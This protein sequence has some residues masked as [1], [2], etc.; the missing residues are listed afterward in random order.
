LQQHSTTYILLFAAAV[1][2]VC[3]V[4]VSGAAVMLGERQ[5]ANVELD[6]Q[7]KVLLVAGLMKEGESLSRSE[8]AKLFQDNIEAELVDLQTGQVVDG[9]DASAFNQR[10]AT[11]DPDTSRE[12]PPNPA[13]VRRLPL[14]GQIFRY[15]QDGRLQAVILPITG[16][17]LWSTLYGYLALGPDLD[18][19]VGITFYEHGETPGLGGE[20]DNPR[21]KALWHGRKAF[22]AKGD[23]AIRVIKGAAGPPATDPYEV[24]G[25]SGATITS[26]GVSSLVRFWLGDE[27]FG[28]Y[29][30]SHREAGAQAGT[31]A[32]PQ[33]QRAGGST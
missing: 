3:S 24:D 9:A 7:Q 31:T 28:P 18:T 19:I 10:K 12:A 25:L 1:C 33:V 14:Q 13:K 26:R 11:A 6:R 20:I 16:K 22:D 17:G 15:V 21:W 5:Q 27:G 32:N 30:Q 8:V 4:F 23:P 29:I 2:A